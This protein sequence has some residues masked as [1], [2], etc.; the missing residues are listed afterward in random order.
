MSP[1]SSRNVL[2]FAVIVTAFSAA[3]PAQ[4]LSLTE[5]GA[6]THFHG[7]AVD[8]R[9]GTRVYLATH[10]GLFLVDREGRAIRVSR[11]ANDYMGFTPHPTDPAVLFA[12]GHPAGGGNLGFIVSDDGGNSWRQLS[13]GV[14][15]PVDFHQMDVS[16]ADPRV[17]FGAFRGLQVSRDGGRSWEQIAPLPER[18]I[19]LAASTVDANRLYAA[20]E[21]GLLYSADAGT[22]WQAA[23][24]RR[25]PATMVQTGYENDV[26]AFILGLGLVRTQ[27][28]DLRWEIV[29]DGFGD[30]Y[31]LHL[32]VDPGDPKRLYVVTNDNEV[33]ASEDGGATWAA[34]DGTSRG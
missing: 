30:R 16:K 25:A 8:A 10:H 9:G 6:R 28:P 27:E 17:I 32:A 22:S 3:A 13:S 34:L 4:T 33:L 11:D 24:F 14:G 12:S 19:D 18:F 2:A 31:L 20:T 26:Y 7:I 5:L 21:R 1:N 15:G 23:H 29:N